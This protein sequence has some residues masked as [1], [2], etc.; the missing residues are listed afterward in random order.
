M[1][2]FQSKKDVVR[3][4]R[5]VGAAVA[6]SAAL[7]LAACGAATKTVSVSEAPG[8]AQPSRTTTQ[9]GATTTTPTTPA[10][11][12]VKVGTFQSP[13]GNIGCIVVGEL[14]RCD[15]R[16]RAWSPPSRPQSCPDVVDF[17]QG[18][19]VGT[20]GGGR[21][22]CA[23]DTAADP[24][25]ER[26]PYGTATVVGPY[27]CVSRSTGVTCTNRATRHGFQISIQSYSR[28]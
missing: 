10:T 1:N 24:S 14:A 22:V 2:L 9:P 28:F 12:F 17:G 7:A 23:G 8:A 18:L 13:T 16:H 27:E 6:T 25:S 19:E 3:A 21:F 20:S 4:V 11:R 15:I 26:L 5:P